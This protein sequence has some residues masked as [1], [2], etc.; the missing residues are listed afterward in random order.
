[1]ELFYPVKGAKTG[2]TPG[3]ALS[4]SPLLG[5]QAPGKGRK[6]LLGMGCG[7]WSQ[8]S[9]ITWIGRTHCCQRA[10]A[11][12]G[13][14]WE[15]GVHPT[16]TGPHDWKAGSGWGDVFSVAQEVRLLF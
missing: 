9:G 14:S 8:S 10:A 11:K 4:S 13:T 16:R 3:W 5:S 15:E 12:G 1:M 7:W 2:Q 6:G